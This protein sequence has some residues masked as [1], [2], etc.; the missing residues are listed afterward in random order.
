MQYGDLIQFDPI[1]TVIRLRDANERSEAHQ[2]VAT[3]A[4]SDEMAERLA[5]VVRVGRL[6]HRLSRPLRDRSCWRVAPPDRSVLWI[7]VAGVPGRVLLRPAD[8]PGGK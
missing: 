6:P 3:Y 2:L 5:A 7:E 8:R 4:I 1:E